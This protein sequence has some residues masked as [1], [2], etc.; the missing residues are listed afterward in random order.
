MWMVLAWM[1]LNNLALLALP[2]L[3]IA[4]PNKKDVDV[5]TSIPTDVKLFISVATET[6]NNILITN[7]KT[8]GTRSDKF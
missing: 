4:T 2:E 8:C 7:N 3:L 5:Q 1:S 6:D